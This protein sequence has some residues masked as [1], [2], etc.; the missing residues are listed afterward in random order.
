[1]ESL[2]DEFVDIILVPDEIAMNAQNIT[3][4][5]PGTPIEFRVG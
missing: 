3:I 1:M 2:W 4:R 5:I